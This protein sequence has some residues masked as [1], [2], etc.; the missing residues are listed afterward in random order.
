MTRVCSFFQGNDP[1]CLSILASRINCLYLYS[2]HRYDSCRLRYFWITGVSKHGAGRRR[3]R[4]SPFTI[5]VFLS[6]QF[7]HDGLLACGLWIRRRANVSRARRHFRRTTQC[8]D[9]SLWYYFHHGLRLYV[10]FVGRFLG[11]HCTLH[12]SCARRNH[13]NYNSQRS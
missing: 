8:H 7:L 6:L 3:R 9:T 5:L 1:Q 12:N 2:G 10:Q 11:Q 4:A 13:H